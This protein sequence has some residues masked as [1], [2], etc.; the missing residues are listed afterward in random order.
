MR[1]T[2]LGLLPCLEQ[3]DLPVSEAHVIGQNGA[4]T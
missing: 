1:N 2:L 4:A 3:G